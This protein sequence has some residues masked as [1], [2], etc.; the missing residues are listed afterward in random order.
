MYKLV[1]T[2][3]ILP[4]KLSAMKAWMKQ[5]DEARRKRDPAYKPYKRYIT[6]FGSVHQLVIELEVAKM[7]EEPLA[8]AGIAGEAQGEFM[9]MIVP[10]RTELR[11]LK[12]LDLG[13]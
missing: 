10:G 9:A 2:H 8:Y 4:G 7:E 11:V 1:L 6:V 12:E 13:S 5:R 3:E